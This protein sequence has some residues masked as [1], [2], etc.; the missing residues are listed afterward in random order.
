MP[1]AAPETRNSRRFM[2][3][4]WTI[5]GGGSSEINNPAA[6]GPAF[7]QMIYDVVTHFASCDIN[8]VW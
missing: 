7:P 2:S 5:I 4:G 8:L 3:V 1:S 6:L